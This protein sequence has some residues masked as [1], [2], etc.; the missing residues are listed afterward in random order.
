VVAACVL[1]AVGVA[2]GWIGSGTVRPANA[3]I[4]R[5]GDSPL[6]MVIFNEDPRSWAD[7]S[8]AARG[9]RSAAFGQWFRSVGG[10]EVNL[11]GA[12]LV[13]GEGRRYGPGV[14]EAAMRAMPGSLEMT[15]FIVIRAASHDE[16][17]RLVRRNP[18][19]GRGGQVIVRRLYP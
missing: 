3:A 19:L 11:G 2:I 13:R 5:Q 7:T 1:V 12:Q 14:A 10:R 4:V 17:A 18:I 16:V 9:E 15:G 6:Y 8:A